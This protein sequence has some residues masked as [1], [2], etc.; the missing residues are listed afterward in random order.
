LPWLAS[1]SQLL[2]RFFFFFCWLLKQKE[3]KETIIIL[4]HLIKLNWKV[5]S[6]H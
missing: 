1:L 3:H 5:K 2:R 6:S 4:W